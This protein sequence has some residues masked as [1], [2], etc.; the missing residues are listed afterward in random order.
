MDNSRHDLFNPNLLKNKQF[1]SIELNSM[2]HTSDNGDTLTRLG[3]I[4][5]LQLTLDK[6]EIYCIFKVC[7]FSNQFFFQIFSIYF[8]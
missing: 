8:N 7:H 3:N 4:E 1:C 6:K 2:F 5:Q